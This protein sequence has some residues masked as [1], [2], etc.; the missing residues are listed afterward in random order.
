M[1]SFKNVE[2]LNDKYERQ[3][4]QNTFHM[5]ISIKILFVCISLV[6]TSVDVRSDF[7]SYKNYFHQMKYELEKCDFIFPTIISYPFSDINLY[8]SL[9]N[10]RPNNAEC[11]QKK[12]YFLELLKD[13][14]LNKKTIYGVSFLSEESLSLNDV[15]SYSHHQSNIYIAHSNSLKNIRYKLNIMRTNS[16]YNFSNSYV[17]YFSDSYNF[18]FGKINLWWGPSEVTSLILSNQVEG[19]PMALI[20]NNLPYSIKAF[21]NINYKFFVGKLENKREVPNAKIMGLRLE[22]SFKN[23]YIGVSRTAQF[24]GKDRPSSLGTIKDILLGNDNTGNRDTDPSNQLAAIDLKYSFEETGLE[25]YGQIA[26]EDE[27]GYLPSRT[28]YNIGLSK[29]L[30]QHK[31]K[32]TIDFADTFSSSSIENY[33]YNHFIYK[34]GYRYKDRPIGASIDADSTLLTIAFDHR[35]TINNTLR[36]KMFTGTINQN[37]SIKNYISPKNFKLNGISIELNKKILTRFDLNIKANLYDEVNGFVKNN[38]ILNLEY[39]L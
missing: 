13:Y 4:I 30:P 37:N 14:N 38:F 39:Q 25:L 31:R 15:R 35:L 20:Q 33:T 7:Q 3:I 26:G 11:L 10:F 23:L 12:V 36:Y 17:S 34:D 29:Y 16:E 5:K 8:R 24:G 18:T 22:A 1:G 21:D 27:S 2:L 32:I 6:I 19:I 28:F 9:D